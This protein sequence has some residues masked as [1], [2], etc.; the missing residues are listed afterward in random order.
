MSEFNDKKEKKDKKDKKEKKEKKEKRSRDEDDVPEVETKKVK[1]AGG[2]S[3][4][5]L[6]DISRHEEEIIRKN[7]KAFV[8]PDV[9]DAD[10]NPP[11]NGFDIDSTVVEALAARGITHMFPI[12]AATYSAIMTGV[13]VIGRARTGTGK[14]LAFALPIIQSLIASNKANP[15]KAKERGR[16]PRV[17]VLSPTRELAVQ[18]CNE[19]ETTAQSLDS[20]C[21][22]GGMP[23]GKQEAAIRKGVDVIVGTC[24]RVKDMLE[25]GVLSFSKIEHIVLDEADEMLN[26][27]FQE[28]VEYI[29]EMV[30]RKERAVQTLLFSATLPEWVKGVAKKFLRDEQETVDLVKTQK[31]KASTSVEHIAIQCHWSERNNV[32]SDVILVHGGYKAR[33]IIFCD[34][35]KE[36]NEIMTAGNMKEDC[37]VIHG[38]IPQAQRET[39]LKAFREGKFNCL[40][41]TDVAAR[42]IDISGVEVVIQ[43]EP[44]KNVETYVH[45]AGRTGRANAKGVSIT[46]FQPKQLWALQQIERKT[47]LM[48]QRAGI[49]TQEQIIKFSAYS[50]LESLMGVNDAVIPTFEDKA[51]AIIEKK[52]ALWAVSAAL[53]V[54]SGNT[55]PIK[56]R[57]LLTNSTDMVTLHVYGEEMLRGLSP[58]WFFIRRHLYEEPDEHIKSM[59]FCADSKGA[60]FDMTREGAEEK[61]AVIKD[62]KLTAAIITELPELVQRDA[63]PPPPPRW[64]EA[65]YGGGNGGS[66]GGGFGGR[67]GSRGGSSGGFGGGRGGFRR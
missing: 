24:G 15:S 2:A 47:G 16:Q 61:L 7:T 32:M 29:L 25:K 49:P 39:T 64:R 30:P 19:F 45:R 44:P 58:I 31:I 8:D 60:V 59:S 27:G 4:G 6:D 11:I 1:L 46:F 10:G 36:A 51:K 37:Q 5:A 26:M 42:G 33:T 56:E 54:I 50:A 40:V 63:L 43:C 52:G 67:G 28:D 57:S 34:T 12:Q 35:K 14:T 13:D 55:Q 41:A 48:F 62:Y 21:I 18:I 17:I 3:T 65:K 22:Y 53:A 23:Y 38:D 9:A 20:F 66:R